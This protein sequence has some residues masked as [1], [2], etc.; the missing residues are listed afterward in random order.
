MFLQVL[1]DSDLDLAHFSHFLICF[2]FH[3]VTPSFLQVEF[4][5][6][7]LTFLLF[8]GGVSFGDFLVNIDYL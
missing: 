1:G 5:S 2:A 7:F 4:L 8:E 3:S 6:F